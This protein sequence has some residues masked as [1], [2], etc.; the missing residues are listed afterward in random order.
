MK[1][2]L[3]HR[4]S[5]LVIGMTVGT[6]LVAGVTLVQEVHYHFRL[7]QEQYGVD[8]NLPGL[9]AHLEQALLPSI[10]WTLAAVAAFGALVGLYAAKRLSAPL[11]D[12]KRAAE[13]I[14]RGDLSVR[15][16]AVGRD[17]LAELGRA[18]NML[19]E[20]LEEQERLRVAMTQ[21]IAHELRTPLATLKS[22]LQ[23]MLD[24]IWDPTPDRLRSCY[25]EAERLAALVADLE[26]L[27]EMDSPDF[28]LDPKPEN[29]RTLVEQSVGRVLAAF[30]EKGVR[31]AVDADSPAETC[32]DRD[33]FIQIMINLLTN[34][35]K[36]TPPGGSVDIRLHDEPDAVRLIVRDT[37]VGIAPE[38][39]PHV[40]ERF[41]RADPSR[42]RKTGGSGLGLA[43][44]KKLVDAHGGSIRLDSA[45]GR[46]TAVTVRLPKAGAA[47]GKS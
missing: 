12:M 22:H 18:L 8:P 33:R 29:L 36:F 46:G 38:H 27:A 34:A 11:V 19:A 32:V 39:I 1:F 15:T 30:R 31:L 2:G 16:R 10:L 42:S 9:I 13:Q 35:L 25:E 24:G 14:M 37:G 6:L 43:I 21:D 3:R 41:Y 47:G 40:F 20:R 5:L 44:V 17:E 23:A 7:Y 45:P 4:L 26:Q 28:R